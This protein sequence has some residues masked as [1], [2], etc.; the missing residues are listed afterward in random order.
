MTTKSVHAAMKTHQI[1]SLIALADTG[2]I[3]GAA[4]NVG[5]TQSALTKSLRELEAHCGASLLVRTS[6]GTRFT[7]AGQALLAHARLIVATM[8]RAEEEVR[9]LA[10]E[11]AAKARIAITPVIAVGKLARIIDEFHRRHPNGQLDIDIGTVAN[12]VE[13]LLDGRLDLAL[14][15]AVP[16]ELPA[17]IA[18]EPLMGIQMIPVTGSR[19]LA[20]RPMS[21]EEA[22]AQR[23]LVNPAPGSTDQACLQWLADKGVQLARP[24]MLCR[25]PFV[26]AALNR[27][28]DMIALC[29]QAIL[30]DTYWGRGIYRLTVPD[31]PPPVPLGILTRRHMPPSHASRDFIDISLRLLQTPASA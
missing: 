4:R 1:K 13:R 29:P 22:T 25:S 10:G 2:S 28:T 19:R 16:A 7:A 12:I 26:L 6:Q 18:F 21:W 30:D 27:R 24:P 31:W 23:W 3:R 8:R 15:I 9:Q 20:E 14:A 17:Q 11:G 5:L